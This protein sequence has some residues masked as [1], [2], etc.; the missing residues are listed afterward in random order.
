MLSA[1]SAV[2]KKPLTVQKMRVECA[3]FRVGGRRVVS[4]LDGIF[5]TVS[6]M[7]R[8]CGKRGPRADGVESAIECADRVS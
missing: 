7:G 3:L 4:T 1:L 8:L 6:T 5:Y 2:V